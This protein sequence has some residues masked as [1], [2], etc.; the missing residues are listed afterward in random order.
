MSYSNDVNIHIETLTGGIPDPECS[1]MKAIANE[2]DSRLKFLAGE[3]ESPNTR[4]AERDARRLAKE[5]TTSMLAA[6]ELRLG[7]AIEKAHAELI[8]PPVV[9]DH[10]DRFRLDHILRSL[11]PD[12]DPLTV[13]AAWNTYPAEVQTALLSA[14]PMMRKKGKEMRVVDL[15]ELPFRE[16]VMRVQRPDAGRKFDGLSSALEK[17]QLVGGFFK[18]SLKSSPALVG[19]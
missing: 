19:G 17:I 16:K 18:T 8:A 4:V 12:L 10:N 9:K 6:A 15:V 11:P 7:P 13:S 3:P 1:A 14:P 2:L 5:S